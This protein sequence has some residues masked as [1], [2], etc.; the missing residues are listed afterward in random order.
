MESSPVDTTIVTLKNVTYDGVSLSKKIGSTW[1]AKM[2][3]QTAWSWGNI[4]L[5]QT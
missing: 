1:I 5:S 4:L 2:I 3:F